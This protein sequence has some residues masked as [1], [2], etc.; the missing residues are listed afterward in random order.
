MSPVEELWAHIEEHKR[1]NEYEAKV[2]A[3]TWAE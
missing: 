3:L 1:I 2:E